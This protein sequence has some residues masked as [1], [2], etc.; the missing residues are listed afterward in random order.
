[1]AIQNNGFSYAWNYMFLE[2]L[3]NEISDFSS[4][5]LTWSSTDYEN[6]RLFITRCYASMYV[7]RVATYQKVKKSLTFH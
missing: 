3:Q 4:I 5:I 7:P 1:M 6:H 2:I